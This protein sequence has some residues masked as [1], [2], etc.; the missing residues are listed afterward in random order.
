MKKIRVYLEETYKWKF[1]YG[2]VVQL[3]CAHNK[4]RLLAQHY[5][6]VAQVTSRQSRKGF[7]VKYNPD[8]HWSAAFYRGLTELQFTIGK[9]ILNRD[10]ASGFHLDTLS[11]HCL[12]RTPVIKGHEILATHTDYVNNHPSVLQT[13][14]YNFSATKTTGE[15]CGGVVKA[16][17]L[18][19]K[20][21][22]QHYADLDMLEKKSK[23]QPAFTNIDTNCKNGL[24]VSVLMGLLMNA[25]HILKYNFGG[26]KGTWRD[27]H[28]SC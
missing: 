5:R 7:E 16:A 28:M 27:Q 18:F 20:N 26:V 12:H 17:G 25:P 14:C 15:L 4:R 9:G 13:T 1:A 23:L 2:T 3:C 11:T 8:H 6:G 24:N 10:D 19:D 21:P 22:A